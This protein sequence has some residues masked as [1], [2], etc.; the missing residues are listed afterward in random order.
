MPVTFFFFDLLIRARTGSFAN[1]LLAVNLEGYK[2]GSN[3][4]FIKKWVMGPS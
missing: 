4:W 1:V 3:F 2:I